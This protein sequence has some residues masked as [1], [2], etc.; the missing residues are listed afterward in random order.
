MNSVLVSLWILIILCLFGT[1]VFE[2]LYA[3]AFGV[4][5]KNLWIVLLAQVVTNPLVVLIPNIILY[6]YPWQE[7]YIVSV[8][9]C[10]ILAVA[11]EWLLYKFFFIK[12]IN[13][14]ERNP[15][16]LSFLLNLFSF[17]SGLA[18]IWIFAVSSSLF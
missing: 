7:Y 15:F 14:R 12:G 8:V 9:V 4:R 13:K 2:V 5:K 16:L 17:L 6:Y 11:A 1:I 3:V 10:E 18:L